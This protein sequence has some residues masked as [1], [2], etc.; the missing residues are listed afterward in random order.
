[1]VVQ[2]VVPTMDRKNAELV[3]PDILWILSKDAQVTMK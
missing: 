3:A 1:M 2:V